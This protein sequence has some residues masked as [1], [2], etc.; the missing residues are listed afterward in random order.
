MLGRR[1]I[2]WKSLTCRLHGPRFFCFSWTT[3][4]PGLS[5]ACSTWNGTRAKARD[6]VEDGDILSDVVAGF[7]P[8]SQAWDLIVPRGTILNL[9]RSEERRV[10]KE[11]R[12]RWS[13]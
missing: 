13:P 3:P 7:S 5:E 11:C 1:W 2:L 9:S 12:S 10:G 8:R 6:Y 4:D